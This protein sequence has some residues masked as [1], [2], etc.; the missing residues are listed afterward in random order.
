MKNGRF[1]AGGYITVEAA[2]VFPMF[3]LIIIALLKFGFQIHNRFLD[4]S[5]T[6]YL[7]IKTESIEHNSYNPVIRGIDIKNAVNSG[8]MG[9]DVKKKESYKVYAAELVKEYRERVAVGKCG[10]FL[11]EDYD[12]PIKNST[13][14]RMLYVIKNHTER[15]FDN[16]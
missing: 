6:E 9:N 14:V 5:L 3:F 10:G 8:L 13:V 15:V 1:R 7:R 12:I 4:Y 2:F 16:D 11:Y